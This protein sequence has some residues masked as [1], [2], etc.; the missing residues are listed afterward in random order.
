MSTSLSVRTV[1]GPHSKWSSLLWYFSDY[2]NHRDEMFPV[3][4]GLEKNLAKSRFIHTLL[5]LDCPKH[6][7]FP[8][9]PPPPSVYGSFRSATSFAAFRD[10]LCAKATLTPNDY[11]NRLSLP[12]IC[13]SFLFLPPFP[14]PSPII[15]SNDTDGTL[16]N[17]IVLFVVMTHGR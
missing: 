7:H 6:S 1:S 14:S 8:N 2:A 17:G 5:V 13:V 3:F 12:S 11:S 10:F 16:L 15:N 4:T 9:S